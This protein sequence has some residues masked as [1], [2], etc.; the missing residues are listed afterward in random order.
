[1]TALKRMMP[2]M[3]PYRRIV[4][5]GILT[6]FL[7]VGSELVV[8]RVLQFVIDQGIRRGDMNAIVQGALVMLGAAAGGAIATLGQGVCRAWLS[9]GMAFDMR[10]DLFNHI[11]SLSFGTLDQMQTGSLMTRISSDIDIIRTFSSN[12]LSLILRA[13][14]MIVGSVIMIVLTDLRLSLVMFACLA[15]AG[16]IIGVFMRIAQPLFLIVQQS[17]SVL[18]TIIQENLAGIR[19][20]KAFVREKFE[21][22][23]FEGQNLDYMNQNVRVGWL[24][25]LVMPTLTVLTNLGIVAV[26]WFGGLDVIGGRLS[27]GQLIAFNNYLMIG[28]TPLLLLGNMLNMASR[29]EASAARVLDLM[30]TRPLI[31]PPPVPYCPERLLGHVIFENVSFHYDSLSNNGDDHGARGNGRENVLDGVSFEVLPGQRVALLGATGS[32]KSTLIN[33]LSRFYDVTGGRV[34]IDGVD[35]RNWD[36]ET[37]RSRIGVV[38]QTTTLFSGTVSENIAFGRPD[39]PQDEIIAVAKA[40]QAHDFIMAKPT[41]Y[42]S[43]VE[44][45][46]ANLSG[47]QKQRIAIAR[48][49]LTAPGILIMDDSTSAVDL[50]TEI[51]IQEALDELGGS[52]TTFIVAQRIN[53]VLNADQ[54]IILEA[55]HIAAQGT[56]AELLQNSPIYQEIY[57]SQFG[58]ETLMNLDDRSGQSPANPHPCVPSPA[59][60]E[61]GSKPLS[62]PTR[63]ER[64]RR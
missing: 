55:G 38:P 32:G 64:G 40:A 57:R 14:L 12:G 7:T 26:I 41:G 13:V 25:A 39:A 58:S 28:M 63:W 15:V 18:N 8:P 43:V 51:R 31:Q 62:S 17:L 37:L 9:Q 35:V 24:L 11:Q 49:L 27:I 33:L 34:L 61:K 5:I 6:V 23:H 4:V 42:D 36:L 54:I 10:N 19:V 1:M 29:A 44:A 53:S 48:A 52:T 60:Q 30:D 56:H 20:V 3:I 22:E 21:L 47:G 59:K 46:G 2:Y 16:M 50:E 45:R